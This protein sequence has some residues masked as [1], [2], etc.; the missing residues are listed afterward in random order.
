MIHSFTRYLLLILCLGFGITS[1]SYDLACAQ[2]S[3]AIK[4]SIQSSG[5]DPLANI[6]VALQGSSLGTSTNSEGRFT[7]SNVPAGNYTLVASSVGYSAKKQNVDVKSGETTTLN[8]QL[9]ESAMELNEVQVSGHTDSYKVDIPSPTLRIKTPLIEVPQNIQV[10]NREM[11]EDQQIFDMLEGVSRNVSGVTRLEHWDNYARLNMRGS[12]IAPFRNGMNVQSSWGPLTED[13]SMVERIEFVKGPAGFMMANGEPSGFYNVVTKKPTGITQGEATI[14]VGSFDTYRATADLD[15]KLSEDGKLLYRLNLM[16]Q[17]KGSHRPYEYNNRYTVAP[18]LKYQIDERTSITAEYTYQYAQTGPIGSAYV[19]SANGYADLPLDFTIAEPNM[20]PSTIHDHSSYL[21]LEHQL[22]ENW[23]LTGQVAYF[24][25]EASG[26][27]FWIAGVDEAGNMQRTV[28]IWDALNTG[29]FGQFFVNGDVQ[30]GGIKHHILAGLDLGSKRYIADWNQSVNLNGTVPFNIYDPVHSVPLDSLPQF[31]RTRSLRQRAGA[32]ILSQSYSGVYIQDE[33]HF[34]EEKIRLTLAGRITSTQDSQYGSGTDETKFTPRAGVSISIDPQSS[35]Y[36]LYD[37][38]FV[39]Q[40]G[41]DVNGNAF[42]PITGNNIE[43]GLKKDWFDGQWNS[44]L[45]VYQITKNNVLVADPENINFSTQLGQTQ[46]SGV[47]LDV[48]GEILPGLTM[49]WNYAYTNSEITED[50]EESNI[51]N[52]V[53]GF[54]KHLTNGWLAY[55]FNNVLE[56]FGIS[57]GYQWQLDR[58]SWSWAGS[59]GQEALPDYFRMDG[60]ISWQNDNFNVALNVNNILD[61]YLYSGS[62]YST[63]YYWQTEPP[64]NFRLSLGYKF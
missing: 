16:G 15:G 44:T 54:A 28:S 36:A 22:S 53:P 31:D 3:G 45:A 34:W 19:F 38:A 63:Y 58:S 12:R 24:N 1:I 49:I 37:Q 23:Q 50:T 6:N 48:K 30:T 20:D 5:G 39:P 60:S 26:S 18:V 42:D 47:E 46:T 11:I 21:I 10:V 52:S 62:A 9:S 33:L 35:V 64:R 8:L 40:T 61:E 27:S 2:S 41:A 43:A 7:I 13:M 32:N 25:Y 56:G 59:T 4:G 17:A 29:K 57:L 51:G 14:T 55:R